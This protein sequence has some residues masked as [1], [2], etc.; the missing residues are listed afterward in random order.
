PGSRLE[1][2]RNFAGAGFDSRVRRKGKLRHQRVEATAECLTAAVCLL[3]PRAASSTELIGA[4][5][6]AITVCSTC[7]CGSILNACD[8]WLTAP[9]AVTAAPMIGC[10][11]FGSLGF[12][13][14]ATCDT[15]PC[16]ATSA[17]MYP[18]LPCEISLSAQSGGT[19]ACA[20][21]N[22]FEISGFATAVL[23]EAVQTSASSGEVGFDNICSFCPA[24]GSPR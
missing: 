8:A 17:L 10:V 1:D 12:G 24:S 16:K 15:A 23:C 7:A 22:S 6:S 14:C 5:I 4:C 19:N 13:L 18:P 11:A 2:S 9:C 21:W 20:G 3:R